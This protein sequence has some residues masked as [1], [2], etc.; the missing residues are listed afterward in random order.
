MC[1]ADDNILDYFSLFHLCKGKNTLQ[2]RS[3]GIHAPLSY[4]PQWDLA[5][6][7]L[8]QLLEAVLIREPFT[9]SLCCSPP[10]LTL[11][12]VCSSQTNTSI[13][14]RERGS[15][16]FLWLSGRPA[17]NT[18]ST[19]SVDNGRKWIDGLKWSQVG[20]SNPLWKAKSTLKLNLKCKKLSA[21]NIFDVFI[22][23]ICW[24]CKEHCKK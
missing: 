12:R 20:I 8:S 23:Y 2:G 11:A 22:F 5:C 19:S 6:H 1:V 3:T 16:Y 15:H 7:I 10:S 18:Q 24:S 17:T 14:E 9:L 13:L 21:I 4:I